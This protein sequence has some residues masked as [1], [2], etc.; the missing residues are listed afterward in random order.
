V[1][2]KERNTHPFPAQVLH[3]E[4]ISRAVPY[5][6]GSDFNGHSNPDSAAGRTWHVAKESTAQST[7][8]GQ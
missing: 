1:A 6:Q 8:S 7:G 3:S 5:A 4:R 2:E